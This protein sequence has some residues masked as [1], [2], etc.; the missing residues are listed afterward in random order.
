M[1]Y[2]P[3]ILPVKFIFDVNAIVFPPK[4][5]FRDYKCT[6]GCDKIDTSNWHLSEEFFNLIDLK[7][8]QVK[9]LILNRVTGM[10][11]SSLEKLRGLHALHTV[12]LRGSVTIDKA[13]G[14]LI[15]SWSRIFELDISECKIESF[16]I[17]AMLSNC[18]LLQNLICQKCSGLDD[19]GLIAISECVLRFRKLHRIDISKNADF[20]DEGVLSL[21]SAG[22]TLLSEIRMTD[23]NKV[24]NLSFA[25]LRKKMRV[26]KHLDI[27]NLKL[28]PSAYEWISEGCFFL[29]FLNISR[30]CT[31]DDNGLIL[32]GRKCRY[33][34]HFDVSFCS[35]ISDEG[36][37]G[38]SEEFQGKLEYI[39]LSSSMAVGDASAI[40]LSKISSNFQTLHLNSLSQIS[41]K[42]MV[43]LYASSHAL[44]SFEM[45]TD[46]KNSSTQRRSIIPH[47]SDHVV[48]A[49]QNKL[50]LLTNLRLSG[51]YL[52]SDAGLC[53]I[54]RHNRLLTILDI[55]Y[56]NSITNQVLLCLG[57]FSQN[58]KQLSISGSGNISDSGILALCRG[59]LYLHKLE[60]HGVKKL[61]DVGVTAIS[62]LGCAL[63]SLN[64][65]SCDDVT[66]AG[67][68]NIALRCT[69][70]RYL[71]I[72]SLDT[73]TS[74]S[75]LA[76]TRNCLEIEFLNCQG[77]DILNIEFQKYCAFLPYSQASLSKNK[78]IR[79]PDAIVAFNQFVMKTRKH[80]A[81]AITL[82]KNIRCFV[83]FR[84][85]KKLLKARE[86]AAVTIQRVFRGTNGRKV[87]K[88]IEEYNKQLKFCVINLQRAMRRIFAIKYAKSK[89]AV[90]KKSNKAAIIV[91]R[92]YRG[93]KCRTRLKRRF[94]N[95]TTMRSIFFYLTQK[96]LIL[97]SVRAT[98]QKI[99]KVQSQLRRYMQCRK[100]TKT[101]NSFSLFQNI[102]RVRLAV[103][104]VTSYIVN[105]LVETNM[106]MERAAFSIQKLFLA[107]RHNENIITFVKYCALHY[108]NEE[109][110][111]EWQALVREES[112]TKIQ[113]KVRG[114]RCR[115]IQ[116]QIKH[117]NV[118]GYSSARRIQTAYR[119]HY[120]Q[121]KYKPFRLH[122]KKVSAM[123]KL[124]FRRN[125]DRYYGFYASKIQKKIKLN[126]YITARKAAASL[127]QR[128]YR[129]HQGKKIGATL[130]LIY[131][132]SK[133]KIIQKVW[134]RY[135]LAKFNQYM[136]AR[137]HIA[138]R[139]IQV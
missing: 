112:A 131:R 136:F 109:D 16:G 49:A 54:I 61:T 139:R 123:W 124:L 108:R 78:I 119:R 34:K 38:F 134:R 102:V 19:F 17:S 68:E 29:T 51:A 138:A 12:H 114:N 64:I 80:T 13:I 23:C 97:R 91:Q 6:M 10:D 47:I 74:K 41:E 28:S 92:V 129:G 110:K 71:D 25:G 40:A 93:H 106:L 82:Q 62:S 32:I 79:R 115:R 20:T 73:V 122:K 15:S 69:N 126:Q 9:Y 120:C 116:R 94:R 52:M 101:I 37:I 77:C 18:S 63:R 100:Y 31:V 137:R 48:L 72:S 56:C 90:H 1:D 50:T 26:L 113:A 66:D 89:L 84:K 83:E 107:K 98:R 125:L 65:G 44:Q 132:H 22:I 3:Q 4:T 67:I 87:A 33:L 24:T 118:V 88:D 75:I 96:L 127:L 35:N 133:I 21:F 2:Y 121:L 76:I 70:M 55:S 103:C 85:Y 14:K 95:Q 58:L 130:R 8:R 59:C 104:R 60:C 36:I 43:K 117:A 135:A 42:A 111:K 7:H 53:H 45:C 27:Q 86:R 30:N 11:S 99:I 39:D 46:I 105:E 81:K 57:E 5:T 128:V